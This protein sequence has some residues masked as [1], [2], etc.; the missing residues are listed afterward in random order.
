MTRDEFGI[1]TCVVP[2]NKDGTPAIAHNSKVK[3]SD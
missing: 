1:W 3:V 2:P